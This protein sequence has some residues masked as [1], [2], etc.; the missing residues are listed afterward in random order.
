MLDK[1][2]LRGTGLFA[3]FDFFRGALGGLSYL[4]MGDSMGDETDNRGSIDP[5]G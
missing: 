1:F 4:S 5:N 3:L 2:L